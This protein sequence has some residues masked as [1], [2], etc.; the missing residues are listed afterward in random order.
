[1]R[2]WLALQRSKSVV[3]ARKAKCTF[4]C[5]S[6]HDLKTCSLSTPYASRSPPCSPSSPPDARRSRREQ[7]LQ[8]SGFSANGSF[9]EYPASSEPQPQDN[10]NLKVLRT[11]PTNAYLAHA[12]RP[13]VDPTHTILLILLV[14][15]MQEAVERLGAL[16]ARVRSGTA[17][18]K[19]ADADAGASAAPPILV[20]A[21]PVT[22]EGKHD[23]ARAGAL[24][25]QSPKSSPSGSQTL[26]L[27]E[28]G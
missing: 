13:A 2:L 10:P 24:A 27:A 26:S 28:V 6:E 17:L 12:C 15:P 11:A 7:V 4:S 25:R 23:E 14:A 19:E 16:L 3:E 9:I 20:P 18:T 22:G 5:T 21:A 1:M 8:A